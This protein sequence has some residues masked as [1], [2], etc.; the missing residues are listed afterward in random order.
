M[1]NNIEKVSR[2]AGTITNIVS[3]AIKYNDIR[4]AMPAAHPQMP[5]ARAFD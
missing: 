5:R 1:K 3:I 4:P 2:T